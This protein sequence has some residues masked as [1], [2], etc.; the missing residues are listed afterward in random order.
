MARAQYPKSNWDATNLAE[1]LETF[2][3]CFELCLEDDDVTDLHK[4]A[5]KLKLSLGGEGIRRI[6][7][8]LHPNE[9]DRAGSIW[10]L[11]TAHICAKR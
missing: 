9:Q 8:G 11:L 2:R 1:E 4:A 5:L 10:K 7:S 6:R 3:Q